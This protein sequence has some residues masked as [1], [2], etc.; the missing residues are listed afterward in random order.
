MWLYTDGLVE[1]RGESVDVGLDR[2]RTAI[3]QSLAL[4]SVAALREVYSS[5]GRP[6]TDDVAVVVLMR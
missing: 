6:V 4:D 2:L 5:L 1:R 3:K